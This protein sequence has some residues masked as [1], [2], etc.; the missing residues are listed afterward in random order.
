MSRR[1]LVASS[2]AAA[3]AVVVGACTPSESAISSAGPPASEA[4]IGL[5]EW[6]FTS[7]A[8][9]LVAGP[10][11]LEVTNAGSTPHDMQVL[12]GDQVLAATAVLKPG[13]SQT[14]RADLTGAQGAALLL[15]TLPGHRSQGMAD[16]IDVLDET[17][18][19]GEGSSG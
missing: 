13:E 9:A 8:E 10:V 7:S 19:T 6:G 14:L 12:V 4:R 2:A 16:E 11:V 17:P 15:C 1:R 3:L 5:V 18:P